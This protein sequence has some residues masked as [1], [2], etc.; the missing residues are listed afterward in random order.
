MRLFLWPRS[1]LLMTTVSCRET[2][3]ETTRLGP[4][5]PCGAEALKSCRST[6][7]ATPPRLSTDSAGSLLVSSPQVRASSVAVEILRLSSNSAVSVLRCLGIPART[8][9]N[10]SSAHD[11]DVSLTTDVYLDEN[12]D[13][14]NH[15]NTDSVWYVL[16]PPSWCRQDPA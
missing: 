9:T 5:R 2:G 11:T 12:L 16:S 3:L 6:I 7:N 15:L 1:T 10:Y 14:I 4:V 8:V 13:P